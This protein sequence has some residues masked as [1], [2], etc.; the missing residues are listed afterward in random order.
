MTRFFFNVHDGVEIIDEE[1]MELPGP[2]DA[3]AQALTT[4]GEMLRDKGR[5]F[6][7]GSKWTMQVKDD[8]GHTVCVLEFSAA[9]R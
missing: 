6:W 8:S 5:E 7:T 2:D 9:R 4:A 1:G 3:R